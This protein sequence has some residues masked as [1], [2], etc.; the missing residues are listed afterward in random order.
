MAGLAPPE[1][2]DREIGLAVAVE[3]G[4]LDVGNPGPPVEPERA[5]L[6]RR[7][8][9]Q[10]DDGAIMVITGD[11]LSEVRDEHVLPPVAVEI[12]ERDVRRMRNAGNDREGAACLLW[13]TGEYRPLAHVRRENVECAVPVE[14]DQLNVRHGGIVRHVRYAEAIM[15]ELDRRLG[16]IRPALGRSEG[17]RRIL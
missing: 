9:A 17:V 8:G 11:E 10:P 2:S 13:M 6:P 14:V 7:Q 5:E 1:G 15:R 16:R 12:G 3:I 4:R